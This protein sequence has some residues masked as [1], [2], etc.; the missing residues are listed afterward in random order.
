LNEGVERVF[1]KTIEISEKP[2]V[3]T[4]EPKFRRKRKRRRLSV[5]RERCED[6]IELQWPERV[7]SYDKLKMD[8][9]NK[10]GLCDRT[11]VTAYLGRAQRTV[12]RRVRQDVWY[13]RS[14]TTVPKEHIFKEKVPGRKGYLEIFGL[15]KMFTNE[16]NGK[17]YFKIFYENSNRSYHFRECLSD[18]LSQEC[19][20]VSVSPKKISLSPIITS[21]GV[22]SN[23]DVEAAENNSVEIKKKE[24]CLNARE[25][26]LVQRCIQNCIR[27]SSENIEKREL[28][29][30]LRVL[31]GAK[32]LSEEP[33]RAR[34][35]WR[36]EG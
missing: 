27:E 35:Q 30:Y 12:V 11:T 3:F 13:R 4:T 1:R 10:L 29:P 33:D 22:H 16:T 24:E 32:P 5:V 36:G 23:G 20:G 17:V 15:A 26:N 19:E 7:V 18:V 14:G 25:R 28:V 6:L 34:V 2:I 21:Q 9:I 8:M 31:L